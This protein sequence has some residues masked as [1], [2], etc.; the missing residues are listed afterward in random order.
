[1]LVPVAYQNLIGVPVKQPTETTAFRE[2]G[3]SLLALSYA[4]WLGSKETAADT[5]RIAA[6]MVI[7]W[8]VLG[9]LAMLWG[10]IFTELPAIYWLY[11]VLYAGFAVAFSVFYPRG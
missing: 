4:G 6:K 1:M 10:L 9:A 7:V 2:L 5:V 3:V 11:A 8:M